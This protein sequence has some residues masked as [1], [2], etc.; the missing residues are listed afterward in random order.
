MSLLETLAAIAISVIAV[1]V[2]LKLTLSNRVH[3]SEVERSIV[4]KEILTNN[5]IELKGATIDSI[6]APGNCLIRTYNIQGEFQS[7]TTQA[8]PPPACEVS[9]PETNQIQIVWEVE[10][11]SAI[12]AS[13]SSESLKLPQHSNTL[14]KVTLHVRGHV[15]GCA[16]LIHN[17]L[18]LFKR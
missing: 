8:G 11:T 5:A 13:F 10:P 12:S 16:R 4:L 9:E 14:R 17:Q 7:E 2:L 15:S 3:K 6:P 18:T 1:S